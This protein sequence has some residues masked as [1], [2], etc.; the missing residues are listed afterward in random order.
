MDTDSQQK[1]KDLEESFGQKFIE[2]KNRMPMFIP[3]IKRGD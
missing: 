2:Y 1:E 3:E